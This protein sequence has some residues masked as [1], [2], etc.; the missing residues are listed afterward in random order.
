MK[1]LD[2][3]R[4]P[5]PRFGLLK[6]VPILVAHLLLNIK[7]IQKVKKKKNYKKSKLHCAFNLNYIYIKK[8]VK[9]KI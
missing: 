4:G 8:N 7:K 2:S 6:F 5:A 9:C 3:H 1:I